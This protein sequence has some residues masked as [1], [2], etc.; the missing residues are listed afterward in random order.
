[1]RALQK[2]GLVELDESAEPVPVEPPAE[3]ET[4]PQ[5]VMDHAAEPVAAASAPAIAVP[6]GPIAEQRPFD[7]IYAEQSVAAAAFTA[8]KLLKILDGLAALDPAA[9]IAAVRALDAADDAWTVDDALLTHLL[10][11]VTGL[12]VGQYV[13]SFGDAHIYENHFEQVD[14]Q[15]RRTPL[16]LPTLKLSDDITSIDGLRV[17]QMSVVGYEHHPPIRGEVAV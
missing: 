16:P 13:H 12:G 5:V 14:E 3:T 11:K 17:E 4:T 7:E 10:A 15:L 8:E 1:M 9:R 2:A 6:A